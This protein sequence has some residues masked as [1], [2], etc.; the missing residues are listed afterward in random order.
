MMPLKF[1]SEASL[2]VPRLA[3]SFPH[4]RLAKLG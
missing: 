2:D 4:E 1:G 3:A